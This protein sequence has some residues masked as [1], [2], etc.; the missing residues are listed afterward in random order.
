[1]YRH[2]IA[3]YLVKSHEPMCQKHVY[4][5]ITEKKKTHNLT[6]RF[7]HSSSYLYF[8]GDQNY[9]DF[10][11]DMSVA[12]Y[13]EWHNRQMYKL[14]QYRNSGIAIIYSTEINR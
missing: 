12:F 1:M 5:N 10:F 9:C 13:R 2:L 8:D 11:C 7:R 14:N 3:K 4:F 6:M